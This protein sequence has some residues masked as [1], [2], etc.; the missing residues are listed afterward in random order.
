MKKNNPLVSI[1]IPVYNGEN[2]IIEAINSALAQTYNNIEVIVVDDGSKD[3]TEKICKSYKNKIKYIYKENGGVASALNLGIKKAKGEY[4]SWLSHDD[5][6]D[7]N[8]IK[9]E[10]DAIKKNNY[11]MTIVTCNYDFIDKNGKYLYQN[12]IDRQLLSEKSALKLLF[13]YTIHGCA[14]LINKNY[15]E[16]I[17]YF[18]ED[19]PMTQDF[20]MWFRIFKNQEIIFVNRILVHSRVHDE[21]GSKKFLKSH[22]EECDRLWINFIESLSK[23]D[24]ERL[25]GTEYDFYEQLMLTLK[26]YVNYPN[27]FEYLELKKIEIVK[28]DSKKIAEY[29][30]NNYN[31]QDTKLEKVINNTKRK[32]RILFGNYGSWEDRGGLN[33]VVANIA[34]NLSDEFEVFIITYGDIKKG[35]ALNKNVNVININF[36]KNEIKMQEKVLYLCKLLDVDVYINPYNCIKSLIELTTYLSQKGIKSIAWNHEYYFLPYYNTDFSYIVPTRN[37]LLKKHNLVMWLTSSSKIF[38]EQ[39]ADN[40]IVM[41]NA[42]TINTELK[43]SD[44]LDKSIISIGRFDDP[45]KNAEFLIILAKKLK[46]SKISIKIKL[47]GSY[48]LNLVGNMT[49]KPLKKLIDEYGLT[50]ENIEFMGFIPKIENVL[51]HAYINILPS[52]HE[53]FGLTII[54]AASYGVPTIAFDDSGFEDMIINQYNGYLVE[55]NDFETIIKI[56]KD[57]YKNNNKLESLSNNCQKYVVKF[58]LENVIKRW[59]DVLNALKNNDEKTIEKFKKIDDR[60]NVVRVLK[61]GIKEYEKSMEKILSPTI[62][63]SIVNGETNNEYEISTKKIKFLRKCYR[64]LPLKLRIK[65]KNKIKSLDSSMTR[66]LYTLIKFDNE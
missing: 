55:R 5:L 45:R 56:I 20:D 24:K 62:S 19:L 12:K 11:R 49:K 64:R 48:N 28:K 27:V 7:K 57:I 46:D 23:S 51:K 59:K 2:Y 36:W 35:Y 26:K 15:F 31:Y 66:K 47:Y 29:L 16:K 61:N 4:I 40:S 14:L 58:S 6:Y 52:Y 9:I 42:L 18:R 17:G 53:G 25:Y 21:Q 43:K 10:M 41:N 34:N 37:E 33:R 1:I 38:Y 50:K 32:T 13:N 63:S 65:V 3:Y 54:E 8:K 44:F 39:F 30:K 22:V 60:I